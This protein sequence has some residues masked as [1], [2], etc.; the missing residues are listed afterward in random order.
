MNAENAE[1]RTNYSPAPGGFGAA[2]S[3]IG[4]DAPGHRVS[5][6]QENN[7]GT[8]QQGPHNGLT[9]AQRGLPELPHDMRSSG[10]FLKMKSSRRCGQFLQSLPGSQVP[11]TVKYVPY[12]RTCVGNTR[13]HL[14]L[15][16]RMA[17]GPLSEVVYQGDL[18]RLPL[19]PVEFL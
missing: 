5:F 11:K 4:I 10:L 19:A 6:D 7:S 13:S 12:V 15:R 3:A 8:V 2:N 14:P 17:T 1:Q 18:A 16:L 9:R